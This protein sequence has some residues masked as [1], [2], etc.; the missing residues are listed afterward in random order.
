MT[1]SKRESKSIQIIVNRG[2]TP[3]NQSEF[4]VHSQSKSN[5][6]YE[7][8][9]RKN[10]WHCNCEDYAKHRKR[11]KHIYAVGYYLALREIVVSVKHPNSEPKCPKCGKAWDQKNVIKRG[12]RHNRN[13][14]VQRYYC[15]HCNRRF[16]DRTAFEGMRSRAT[17]IASALDLYYRGLSLRQI[18]EHLEAFY[19]VKVTHTT[20]YNWIKKYVQLVSQYVEKLQV[21]TSDRWHADD[22]LV[23]IRGRHLVLWALLDSETRYLIALHISQ[24]R[25]TEDAQDF[26]RKGLETAKNKPVEIVTDGLRSYT[27]AID[28]E[29]MHLKPDNQGLIHVQGPLTGPLTN[30]K[31]ERFHG[32]LK[33][34]TKAMLNL[35]NKTSTETFAKG[36][37]TY[38]N[39]IKCHSSL[40]GTTPAQAIGVT[41]S[42]K[43]WLDLIL[44]AKEKLNMETK[45]VKAKSD[46]SSIDDRRK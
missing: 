41:Q 36:F 12:V 31:V 35:G 1:L 26:L 34:R 33:G 11:C 13:G 15:K 27:E 19:S 44:E 29:C 25:T 30:N 21:R 23:R 22:T 43:G 24:K 17:S 4:L 20:V 38:Y 8:T 32:V 5:K 9:W 16:G 7:V 14:P 10:H 46:V 18:G 6:W 37:A 2:V 3:V 28:R 45:R 40:N 42:K 39:F